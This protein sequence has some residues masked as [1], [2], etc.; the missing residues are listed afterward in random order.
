MKFLVDNALSPTLATLLQQ[1]GHD[2]THV[3]TIGLQRERTRMGYDSQRRRV[4]AAPLGTSS[5]VGR[6]T[7]QRTG[8]RLAC[9][10]LVRL[11]PDVRDNVFYDRLLSCAALT[12]R[13]VNP[14]SSVA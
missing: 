12:P 1:A 3:R 5:S 14:R 7:A 10:F 8:K 2:A 13:G 4:E 11:D 9:A 6:G